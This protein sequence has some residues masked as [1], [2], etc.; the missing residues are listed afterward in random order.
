M[1]KKSLE[2]AAQQDAEVTDFLKK[3]VPGIPCAF[4]LARWTA[5]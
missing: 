5:S 2:I 3:A 4:V 1:Q